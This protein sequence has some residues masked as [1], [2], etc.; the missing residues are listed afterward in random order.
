MANLRNDY[1]SEKED[2]GTE[3]ELFKHVQHHRP[4]LLLQS[5]KCRYRF[6][7]LSPAG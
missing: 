5:L 1:V 3:R 7:F 4:V 6:A 2:V